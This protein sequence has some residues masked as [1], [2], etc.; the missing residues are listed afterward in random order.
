MKMKFEGNWDLKKEKKL[1]MILLLS[2]MLLMMNCFKN[3]TNKVNNST[4]KNKVEV[5]VINNSSNLVYLDNCNF[6]GL[7]CSC[8]CIDEDKKINEYLFSLSPNMSA[9]FSHAYYD[10]TYQLDPG[11]S[12]IF[13]CDEEKIKDDNCY[14]VSEVDIDYDSSDENTEVILTLEKTKSIKTKIGKAAES[15]YTYYVSSKPLPQGTIPEYTENIQKYGIKLSGTFSSNKLIFEVNEKITGKVIEKEYYGPPNYGE[16]PELDAKEIGSIICFDEPKNFF[17]D[18]KLAVIK[19]MQ[20]VFYKSFY[21]DNDWIPGKRYSFT[22]R[23]IPAE[24]GHH[25]T[26]YILLVDDYNLEEN[27]IELEDIIKDK[28]EPDGYMMCN[29]ATILPYYNHKL[30]KANVKVTVDDSSIFAIFYD[31]ITI[32]SKEIIAGKTT[33]AE[34]KKI[35]NE[36]EIQTELGFGYFVNAADFQ[37]FFSIDKYPSDKSLVSFIRQTEF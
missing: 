10:F 33:Y 26:D 30:G 19:E 6:R 23:I 16:T 34:L 15:I 11:A 32:N 20:L 9:N 5:V 29:S 14:K 1:M 31:Q 13:Y 24:T 37:I 4:E 36:A 7:A 2:I 8:A 3:T 18:E 27:Q 28:T 17:V 35:L 25:H 22:G 21:K 12:V